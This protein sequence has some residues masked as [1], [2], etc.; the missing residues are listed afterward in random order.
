MN[1]F[2]EAFDEYA[3]HLVAETP[4]LVQGNVLA[5]TDGVRLNVRECYPLDDA[6]TAWVRKITWLL[7]P[8]HPETPA[9]LRALRAAVDANLGDTRLEFAVVFEDRIAAVAEVSGGLSWR[10]APAQ[11]QQLRAHPAVAGAL[12]QAKR[13]QL[14]ENRR[15]AKRG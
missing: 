13:L 4:V 6:V 3:R 5:G 14:R 7:R 9:F 15:W 8:D 10:V 1:M 2:S 12:V 11:F